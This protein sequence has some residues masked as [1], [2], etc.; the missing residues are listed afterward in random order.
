MPESLVV[1]GMNDLL[2]A[3]SLVNRDLRSDVR[4]ALEAAAEPVRFDAEHLALSEISGMVRSRIP[5]HGMRI[6]VTQREVYVAPRQRGL[7]S[8]TND[9]RRRPNLFALLLQRAMEPAL[10]N[11]IGRVERELEDQLE[12]M[13]RLWEKI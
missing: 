4:T 1:E 8:R 9:R 3:L 13:R 6:G 7:K 12:Q 2:R 5:W 10:E 11:N